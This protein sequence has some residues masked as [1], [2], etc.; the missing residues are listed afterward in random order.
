MNFTGVKDFFMQYDITRAKT[1]QREHWSLS[2]FP[3]IIAV[4]QVTRYQP[5]GGSRKTD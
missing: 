4:R 5:C 1:R 2:M 3:E